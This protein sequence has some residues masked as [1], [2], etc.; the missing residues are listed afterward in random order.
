MADHSDP[1]SELTLQSRNN[2][3]LIL[4]IVDPGGVGAPASLGSPGNRDGSPTFCRRHKAFS[5]KLRRPGGTE[6]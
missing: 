4:L 5:T 6:R 2:A 1:I 3:I